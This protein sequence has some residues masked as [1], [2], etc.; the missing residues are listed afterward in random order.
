MDATLDIG[1]LFSGGGLLWETGE[2][3][4]DDVLDGSL[5]RHQAVAVTQTK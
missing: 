2:V 5:E 3:R 4:V 1:V